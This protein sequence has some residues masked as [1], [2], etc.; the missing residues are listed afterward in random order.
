VRL[1]RMLFAHATSFYLGSLAIITG[2]G[3]VAAFV[4]ARAA[5]AP[6]WMWTSAAA[7]AL[8]PASEFAVSL[9]NR[10][11]HRITGPVPLLRLDLRA[12]VPEMARTMVIVPTII[13]SV[14]GVRALVEHLEVHAL[15]NR[16]ANVHFALLTD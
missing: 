15:G 5:G 4:A 11:V 7:L 12:G 6:H 14:A 8:I 9:V 16:D 3:A 13:S 2:L 1:E 10:V